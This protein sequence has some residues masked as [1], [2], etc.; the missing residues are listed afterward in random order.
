MLF[1]GFLATLPRE[2]YPPSFIR[3]LEGILGRSI[4][5]GT[6][7]YENSLK[8]TEDKHTFGHNHQI[9]EGVKHSFDQFITNFDTYVQLVGRGIL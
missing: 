8:Y 1:Y 2:D 9:I 5:H 4:S 3:P 6:I 7:D